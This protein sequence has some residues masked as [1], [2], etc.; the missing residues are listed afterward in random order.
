MLCKAAAMGDLGSFRA[1][2]ALDD[3]VPPSKVKALGR[4][5]SG[6]RE[7]IWHRVV[8]TVAFETVF[9]KFQKTASLQATLL[10]TG[11]KL[12]AEATSHDSNWGIGIDVGDARVKVPSQW[13]GT[14]ILGWALMECRIALREFEAQDSTNRVGGA[15]SSWEPGLVGLCAAS[16]AATPLCSSEGT[17]GRWRKRRQRREP[18]CEDL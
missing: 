13:R 9:Q 6:F 4:K 10:G 18:D 5:V 16:D 2:A 14:N 1:I 7:E 12:I 3:T 17:S 8:C 15:S 11:D